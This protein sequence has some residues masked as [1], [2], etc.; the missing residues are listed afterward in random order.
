MSLLFRIFVS[1]KKKNQ[2]MSIINKFVEIVTC[3]CPNCGQSSIYYKKKAGF[4]NLPIMKEHCDKCN[5]KLNGEP[6]YF[7]GAMFVS[8]GLAV[9][10]GIVT[11]LLLK[12][13]LKIES[14]PIIIAGIMVVIILMSMF[15]YKL[16][17]VIW[18]NVFPK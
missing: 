11:F 2:N 17:R 15:N 14:L 9:L 5:F 13:V 6:G 12:V 18:M 8:Y 3:Q 10:Q 1:S 16:S 7:L 4:F